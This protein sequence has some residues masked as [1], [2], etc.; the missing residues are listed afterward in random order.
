M[1]KTFN[2]EIITPTKTIM[3]VKLNIY[4]HLHMMDYLVLKEAMQMQQWL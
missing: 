4:E 3:K 1:S 2:L